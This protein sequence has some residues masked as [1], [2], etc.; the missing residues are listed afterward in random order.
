MDLECALDPQQ[1]LC[2]RKAV[3]APTPFERDV[4]SG[5]FSN[6]A[7]GMEL[8]MKAPCNFNHRCGKGCWGS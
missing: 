1:Q 5:P 8:L 3:E 7:P 4:E 2:A 6:L